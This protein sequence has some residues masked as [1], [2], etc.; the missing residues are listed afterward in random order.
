MRARL[1]TTKANSG[2]I[3]NASEL[4]LVC[5]CVY[6]HAKPLGY[7]FVAKKPC[8]FREKRRSIGEN[9]E[10]LP[11]Q[12][13]GLVA[14]TFA[15]QKVGMYGN[16]DAEVSAI[17]VHIKSQ[18]RRAVVLERCEG[19]WESGVSSFYEV[20]LFEEVSYATVA[21]DARANVVSGNVG[22]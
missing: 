19:G 21:I 5:H 11:L 4:S 1:R 18:R 2:T 3:L 12:L 13:L 15:R 16:R 17:L 14:Q 7:A 10:Y 22:I 9:F 20:Q 8:E 6:R